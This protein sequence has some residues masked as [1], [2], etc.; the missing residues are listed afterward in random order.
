MRDPPL[1]PLPLALLP[2]LPFPRPLLLTLLL[3][4]FE[5]CLDGA[6]VE[7]GGVVVDAVDDGK[8]ADVAEV[9]VDAAAE[10][11]ARSAIAAD[12]AGALEVVDEDTSGVFS[13][14]G[15]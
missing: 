15:G 5:D 3:P 14:F 8:V 6:P 10:E 1:P 2:L 4:A 7:V 12:D 9:V 11:E 13:R